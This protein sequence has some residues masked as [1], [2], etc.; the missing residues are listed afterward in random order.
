MVFQTTFRV[1][2]C[3]SSVKGT[4]GAGL[5]A[6]ELRRPQRKALVSGLLIVSESKA[7]CSSASLLQGLNSHNSLA[8]TSI[9]TRASFGNRA[10]CTVER[11]G[12]TTPL[13][14][15]TS[16]RLVHCRESFMLSED[17][18]LHHVHQV[19]PAAPRTAFRF[20]RTRF[21]CSFTSPGPELQS[22]IPTQSGRGVQR[23]AY[24][25]RL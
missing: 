15:D 24:T 23:I 6:P 20:S 13:E 3:H 16:H 22:P 1:N 14:R 25:N 12:G 7:H 5:Q 18:R 4:G 10:T 17:G 19:Q 21:V 2:S 8:I 9:S 11:A